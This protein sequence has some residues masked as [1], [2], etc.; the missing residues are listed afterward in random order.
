MLIL[1]NELNEAIKERVKRKKVCAKGKKVLKKFA[2]SNMHFFR[3][4]PWWFPH[5]TGKKGDQI[6]LDA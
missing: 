5:T 3:G 2:N 6:S 4:P 1:V